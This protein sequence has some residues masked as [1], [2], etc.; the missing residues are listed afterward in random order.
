[1]AKLTREDVK[2]LSEPIVIEA[3]ILGDKEYRVEKITM[4]MLDAVNKLAPK[5]MAKEQVPMDTPVKQLALL[6]KVPV[7]ELQGFDLRMIGKVLSF[8]MQELT[9]GMGEVKNPLS[10]EAKL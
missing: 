7:E 5:E 3:G 6:L 2:Q 4:D 8:I 9:K 10:A 1:M